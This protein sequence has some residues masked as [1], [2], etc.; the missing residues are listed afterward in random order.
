MSFKA[1]F[2]HILIS[3]LSDSYPMARC[4]P[5]VPET[6]FIEGIRI[7]CSIGPEAGNILL[8]SFVR[9]L[10]FGNTVTVVATS[11]VDSMTSSW[12]RNYEYVSV[13]GYENQVSDI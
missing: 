6:I 5:P 1:D 10:L 9:T 2:R 8:V 3:V 13:R 12:R 11:E 7:S 4:A